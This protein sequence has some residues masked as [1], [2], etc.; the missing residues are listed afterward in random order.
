MPKPSTRI[1]SQLSGDEHLSNCDAAHAV[2]MPNNFFVLKSLRKT[3]SKT[4]ISIQVVYLF[5]ECISPF[6]YC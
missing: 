6:S 3:Q 5:G 4:K 1:S 2:H